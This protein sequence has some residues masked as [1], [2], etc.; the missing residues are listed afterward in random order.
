MV[1]TLLPE[2]RENGG[3]PEPPAS[4]PIRVVAAHHDSCGADTQIRLPG[5]IPA[6][7]IRRL[8]CSVCAQ[9]FATHEVQDRGL[10]EIAELERALALPD[11]VRPD[12]VKP[13]RRARLSTAKV[14]L[15]KLTKPKL[16]VPAVALPKLTVPTLK[17]PELNRR[18]KF[19]RKPVRK[20]PALNPSS[21][22][23]RVLSIPLAAA[24]VV[25]GLLLIQGGGSEVQPTQ[26]AA[27][28]AA[29]SAA[30]DGAAIVPT[31]AGKEARAAAVKNDSAELVRG[32]AY[33]LALPAGWKQ[34]NPQSGAT[35]AA[36]ADDGGAD[37]Q[38]WI[39]E[40]PKLDFPT[41]VRQSLAQLETLAGSAQIIERAPAPT[42]DETVVRLA[43]DAP[44]GEPSYEV[45]LRVA[46]PYRYYLATS[47]QPGASQETIEGSE[48]LSGS[49]EPEAQG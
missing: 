17:L 47:V 41:F 14:A 26:T 8:N 37:A 3:F 38:L 27:P 18:P 45:T 24:A 22:T 40:D 34:V 21:R 23:W 12:E 39:S 19:Q 35:F 31:G 11:A 16:S 20:L 5:T 33:S 43:A 2:T 15:P 7:A 28:A 10:E 29:G 32:S 36:V 46:G 9:P 30:D 44:A 1:Q 13:S 42:A 49:F 6:H 48:L 25:G 4:E